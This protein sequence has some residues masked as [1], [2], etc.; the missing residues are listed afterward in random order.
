MMYVNNLHSSMV[1]SIALGYAFEGLDSRDP[2]VLVPSHDLQRGMLINT[3]LLC[4][5]N[6]W[7]FML[8]NFLWLTHVLH[9]MCVLT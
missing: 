4:S 7:C 2:I 3:P 1:D 6:L 8:G 9:R 5:R